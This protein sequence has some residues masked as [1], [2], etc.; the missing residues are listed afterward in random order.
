MRPGIEYKLTYLFFPGFP[1]VLRIIKPVLIPL[2]FHAFFACVMALLGIEIIDG[3][4]FIIFLVS[5]TLY[6]GIV[7]H[8][9]ETSVWSLTS[10]VLA[11]E[12]VKTKIQTHNEVRRLYF[13]CT[14]D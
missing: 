9:E 13:N 4:P 2:V 14:T 8:S 12:A 5:S 7:G 1:P 3:K 6:A 11:T 10:T